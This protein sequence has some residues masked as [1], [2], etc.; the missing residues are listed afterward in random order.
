M[1]PTNFAGA[2]AFLQK[3]VDNARLLSVIWHALGEKGSSEPVIYEL[4][5]TIN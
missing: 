3:P 5:D 1:Q 2:I 4:G